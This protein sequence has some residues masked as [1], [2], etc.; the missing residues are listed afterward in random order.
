MEKI[1]LHGEVVIK[2][3]SG[4]IP[5]GAVKVNAKCGVYKI[6]DSESSGN[7]HLL[8]V[9]EG[10][11]MYEK[12]GVLYFKNTEEATVRCVDEKRHDTITI[13]PCKEDEILIIER[14]LEVDHLTDEVKQVAD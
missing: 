5:T 2:K 1:W 6:A 14:Q 10:C 11:E 12:D 4:K 13:E 7:H 9:I 8:E 3:V